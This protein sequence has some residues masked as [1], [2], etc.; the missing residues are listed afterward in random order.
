MTHTTQ[1]PRHIADLRG[2]RYGE[3]LLVSPDGAGGL[4]AA[5]YN[6][7]GLNDCPAQ[8]WNGLD[9]RALAERFQV[10]LVLLNGPR[11]WVIDE[12]TAFA[13]GKVT[14]FG[15]VRARLVAEVRIPAETDPTGAR[16]RQYYIDTTVERDTEYVLSAGRPVYSLRDSDGRVYVLQAYAHIVDDSLTLDSLDT[17]GERLRL[18]R[19]WRYEVRTPKADLRVRTADGEAHVVQDELQNTYMLLVT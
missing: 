12:L 15:G 17:L 6:T 5:V 16:P 4:K 1:A 2:K 18:P 14:D 7:L 10:P 11:Y 13:T 8:W 3:I 19:G 9:P